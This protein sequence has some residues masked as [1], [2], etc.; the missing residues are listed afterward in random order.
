LWRERFSGVRSWIK[1]YGSL[2]SEWCSK[3]VSDPYGV[4]IW[5]HIRRG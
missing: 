2:G 3:V 1:K 5:K 4:S